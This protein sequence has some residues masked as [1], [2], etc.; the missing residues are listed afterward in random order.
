MHEA[1][2]IVVVDVAGKELGGSYGGNGQDSGTG[3]T[4]P[5]VAGKGAGKRGWIS[6]G[7]EEGCVRRVSHLRMFQ[8]KM[9]GDSE[10][11]SD[12]RRHFTFVLSVCIDYI[13]SHLIESK[14]GLVIFTENALEGKH[15]KKLLQNDALAFVGNCNVKCLLKRYSNFLLSLYSKSYLLT[16]VSVKNNL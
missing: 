15:F 7:S 1:A 14:T 12:Y 16:S 11:Y 5:T 8:G 6:D 3:I 10:G 13:C 2:L 9:P 4:P